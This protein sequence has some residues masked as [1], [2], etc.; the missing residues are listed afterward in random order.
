MSSFVQ[1]LKKRRVFRVAI[2][3]AITAWLVVQIASTVLPTFH[4]PEW[5]LQTLIVVVALGFPA[6]L[7]LAWAFDVTPSGIEKAAEADQ[8]VSAKNAR[9][10]WL[11]AC[12]G[13]IIAGITIGGYRILHFGRVQPARAAQSAVDLL[14]PSYRNTSPN[15]K[16]IAVLPFKSLSED[17]ANNYFADGIQDEILTRLSK[18]AE[19]KVISRTST[20]KYQSAP[21]NLRE[22]AQQLGVTNILEGSVQKAGDQVRITVQLINA[23]TDAHL[24]AETYD[25]KLTDI[26]GVESEVAQGIA[27]SLEARLTGRERQQLAQIPTKNPQAYDAYLR[28]IALLTRQSND[29][30]RKARDFLQQAVELDPLYA[31]AWA[32]LAIAESQIYFQDE[33]TQA[34]LERARRAAETCMRLQPESGEAHTALGI[35]YYYGF[36]DFDRA[37]AEMDEARKRTPNAN[38]IFFNIGLV[39]RRQGKV[40][41]A[42]EFMKKAA[43]VDPRN[44]DIWV[45]LGTT[46]RGRRDFNSAREMIARAHAISPDETDI[47]GHQAEICLAQGDLEDAE[48]ILHAQKLGMGEAFF[49][50]VSCLIY[51]HQF[52]AAVEALSEKLVEA[53][54]RSDFSYSDF[55]GWIGELTVASGDPTKGRT[56][57][58]QS[59]RELLALRAAGNSSLRIWDSL[60]EMNAAL[61]DRKEMEREAADLRQRTQRDLWRAPESEEVVA[62]AY[63]ILNDA[64]RAMP[65][66]TQLLSASYRR[67]LTPALLHFDPVWDKIR[68]DPRFQK[69][70]N[71]RP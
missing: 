44:P 48:K 17:K 2:G 51:R 55:K 54:G 30:V 20:Q 24:W 18:I 61:G 29:D 62:R 36:Q 1:E 34:Q 68:N 46:Y 64:D 32:Q 6:A 41:E 47:I 45:N 28:G 67:S 4:V 22:I 13:L 7:V 23:T 53:Q 69:L 15:E 59:L 42:I 40:E 14:T 43:L 26:F 37:L 33:H 58:E 31:Q 70:A 65:I 10:A 16:S 60:I 9:Q 57:I 3:Y 50:S 56:L 35:F 49:N 5:V 8:E 66:I 38:D 11:L 52:P 25:R 63:A 71:P 39:K 19:L 27:T 12:T 21:D